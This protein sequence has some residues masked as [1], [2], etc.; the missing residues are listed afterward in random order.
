MAELA[1]TNDTIKGAGLDFNVRSYK[2][3][4]KLDFNLCSLNK[5]TY[6]EIGDLPK[7]FVPRNVAIVELEMP[8]ATGDSAATIGI[9][10]KSDSAKLV[11][12]VLS[13]EKG[14]TVGQVTGKNLD[15]AGDT[16]CVM[17]DDTPANGLVKIVISGDMMTDYWDESI[18][19]ASDFNAADHVRVN[20]V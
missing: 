11:E 8:D 15:G 6:Y 4:R 2:L 7:G 10:L 18:V 9:Y 3:E 16:I 13:T 5:S 17:V 1:S 14:L 19:Q 20:K 12:R